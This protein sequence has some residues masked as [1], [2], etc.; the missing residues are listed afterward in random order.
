MPYFEI[1]LTPKLQRVYDIVPDTVIG[2]GPQCQIQLLSRAVSRRHAR[3]EFGD[4]GEAIIS[5]LGTKNGIKLN[6]QRI[7]G[8]AVIG[9]GDVLVVGDVS[10]V[11]RAASRLEVAADAL[12]FRDRPPAREDLPRALMAQ[13]SFLIRADAGQVATFQQTIA[14]A[15]IERLE[16]DEATRF[17]LQIALKEALDNAR[18]HGSKND[19]ARTIVVTFSEDPDEFLMQ[20]KDEGPGYDFEQRLAGATEVDAMEAIRNRPALG[21]GLGLRIILNCI[22]RLQFEG[23]GAA[24]TMGKFKEGGQIFVISDESDM[25]AAGD[26]DPMAVTDD[27]DGGYGEVFGMPLPGGPAG[28]AAPFRDE[29]SEDGPLRL[30]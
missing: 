6:G 22:D 9:E 16:F 8:A 11:F 25:G 3:V 28:G 7:Q 30:R 23:R 26:V 20:V 5:D 13:A 19:R 27:D 4:Q 18:V 15:R 10:M 21:P 24:I 1:Q 14:R 29:D 2:R 17:K 12:D